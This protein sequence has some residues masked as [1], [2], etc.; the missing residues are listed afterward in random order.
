MNSKRKSLLIHS[1]IFPPDQVSTAYLYGD[2]AKRF[3]DE[4][5][6]VSVFT[7]IPH[8]NFDREFSQVAKRKLF[9]YTSNYKGIS[10]THIHQVKAKRIAI[11]GLYIAFFHL[12]FLIR[13]FFGKRPDVILTP[14]PPLTAGLLSALVGRL[15]SAK[16]IYNVQEVYPDILIKSGNIKN[17]LLIELLRLLEKLTYKWSNRITTI[18]DSFAKTLIERVPDNKLVV[19][20]NFVD[21]VLYKPLE[22]IGFPKELKVQSNKYT[23][24]YL[25]NLGKL[26]DWESLLTCADGLSQ[27]DPDIQI[28]LVGGGAEY[29]RLEKESRRR[30]N[31]LVRP[32][33]E[34]EKIPEIINGCDLHIICMNEAS[35]QDGLPSKV[36]TLLASGAT[37]LAATSNDSPLSKVLAESGNGM[38][39]D[40]GSPEQLTEA[41]LKIKNGNKL[42]LSP[43]QGRQ[44][45]LKNYSKEAITA[46]YFKLAESLLHNSPWGK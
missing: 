4:G 37:V 41:I 16:V 33:Q 9:H 40:L 39:V 6:D 38:R 7:T 19:I 43:F 45:I 21:T 26:Q 8:Y 18:D 10:V 22:S 5:W 13:G 34:R 24:G 2:I 12:A 36:Y 28:L 20:P 32:Y 14:S 30:A 25:G 3:Y 11:R 44:Y 29:K 23:V 1:L 31:L 46:Q 42:E 27:S 15:R 17:S 35:D